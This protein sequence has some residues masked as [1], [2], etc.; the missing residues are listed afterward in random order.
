MRQTVHRAR[1]VARP[2]LDT[3]DLAIRFVNTMAWRLREPSE[4]RMSSPSAL[5]DWLR[6]SGMAEVKEINAI[7]R[8]WKKRP[9]AALEIYE[10]A[11]RLREAIYNILIARIRCEAPSEDALAFFNVMLSKSGPAL[12][13]ERRGEF[14]WRRRSIEGCAADLLMPIVFS[15]I[16]LITGV[17]AAKVRQCQDDRGCGWLFVDDSRIQNRR[18]CSMGDCGNRAKSQRHHERVRQ[19]QKD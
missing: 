19:R 14:L 16:E 7:A 9:Q 6:T 12:R 11:L 10:T 15:A 4:E 3:E 13:V 18:W 17:R 1:R 8:D 5:L 2:D